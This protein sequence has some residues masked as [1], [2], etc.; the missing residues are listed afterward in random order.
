MC[1]YKSFQ[2]PAQPRCSNGVHQMLTIPKTDSA[3]SRKS[4][5]PWFILAVMLV[6]IQFA[7]GIA[8]G[9]QPAAT[10]RA[11]S[12]PAT[13]L[14]P[15]AQSA[16]VTRFSF[17]D[18]GDTRADADGTAP[19]PVHT[20]LISNMLSAIARLKSTEYPVRFVLQSGDGVTNGS[21]ARQWNNSYI[22][23]VSRL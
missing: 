3:K 7:G 20:Q 9:Q 16:G 11:I 21:D 18:Y 5:M 1:H 6:T 2:R 19:Q 23:V 17:I 15:E 10:V 13:P 12:A 4:G 8:P 22:E 14:P